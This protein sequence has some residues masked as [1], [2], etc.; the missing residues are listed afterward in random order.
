MNPWK[1]SP[2]SGSLGTD[3]KVAVNIKGTMTTSFNAFRT[4]DDQREP[5]AP[6]GEF[7]VQDGV[8]VHDA[9][10]GSVTTSFATT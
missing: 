5:H 7:P 9:P 10:G 2:C 1:L 4:S 6:L 8:L 3:R